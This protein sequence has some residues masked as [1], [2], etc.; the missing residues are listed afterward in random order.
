MISQYAQLDGEPG[1][2]QPSAHIL[3]YCLGMRQI[4]R[5][6]PLRERKVRSLLPQPHGQ[7]LQYH[8]EQGDHH[9]HPDDMHQHQV[10]VVDAH[11]R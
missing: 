1:C 5:Q 7:Q 4:I 2:N 6:P 3:Q 11:I 9:N 10:D 8:G